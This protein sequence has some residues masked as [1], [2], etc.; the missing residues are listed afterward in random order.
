M[1]LTIAVVVFVISFV[2]LILGI[3]F[4][5][6]ALLVSI[7]LI[8][9]CASFIWIAIFLPNG[10]KENK[11]NKHDSTTIIMPMKSGNTTIYIPMTF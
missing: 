10:S 9:A 11:S 3:G 5:W 2:L 1:T 7:A 4:D 8:V 6:S